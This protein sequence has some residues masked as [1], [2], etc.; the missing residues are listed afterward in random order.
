M[1]NN[2]REPVRLIEGGPTPSQRSSLADL[3]APMAAKRMGV[4]TKTL[5]RR[6]TAQRAQSKE[7]P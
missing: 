3:L 5:K 4:S 6:I 7:A 1:I 2:P